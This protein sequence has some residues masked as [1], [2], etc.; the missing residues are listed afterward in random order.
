MSYLFL[1][2]LQILE[3]WQRIKPF[4]LYGAVY[5]LRQT[6]IGRIVILTHADTDI[7]VVQHRCI[8]I[9]RI[10]HTAVRMVRRAA[11][12]TSACP[13]HRL[14]QCLHRVLGFKRR[15]HYETEDGTRV[16]IGYQMQVARIASLQRDIS[17]IGHPKRVYM[18]DIHILSK[19][20]I[21]K[22]QVVRVGRMACASGRNNQMMLA[23][24]VQKIVP[25]IAPSLAHNTAHNIV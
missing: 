9:T 1:R 17:D 11:Q 8:S 20:R 3:Q 10:L 7:V 12:I 22:I 2:L 23:H 16:I 24:Q 13:H 18:I 5:P 6:V 4:R 14:L 15:R 25:C 19:I 21:L